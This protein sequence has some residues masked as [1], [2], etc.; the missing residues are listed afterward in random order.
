MA[1]VHSKNAI[2][3]AVSW[4]LLM[5]LC[6]CQESDLE[7]GV[8]VRLLQNGERKTISLQLR[9]QIEPRIALSVLTLM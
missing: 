4:M 6:S 8:G 5:G 3:C 9:S 1:Q 7:P 2:P